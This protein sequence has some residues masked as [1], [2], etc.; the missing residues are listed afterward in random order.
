MPQKPSTQKEMLYQVWFCL[1][2]TNGDGLI[3]HIKKM[4]KRLDQCVTYR[5]LAFVGGTIT[6]LFGGGFLTKILGIW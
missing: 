2:G 3:D 1:I 5:V 6:L 4:E